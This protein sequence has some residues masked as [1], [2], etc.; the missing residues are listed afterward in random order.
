M[1]TNRSAANWSPKRKRGVRVRILEYYVAPPLHG[2]GVCV[3]WLYF[4]LPDVK[5]TNPSLAL[6]APAW[7][8]DS[9]CYDQ[10]SS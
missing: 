8:T 10:S 2:G 4:A 1:S 7:T 3:R 6:R 9:R 5:V